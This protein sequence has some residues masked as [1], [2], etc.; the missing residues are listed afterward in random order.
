MYKIHFWSTSFQSA[1][2]FPN[3]LWI[4]LKAYL[5]RQWRRKPWAAP[6]WETWTVVEVLEVTL[7]WIIV[8]FSLIIFRFMSS[9]SP[10]KLVHKF[11]VLL[12]RV[13]LYLSSLFIKTYR[14]KEI[15]YTTFLLGLSPYSPAPKW[16]FL[17][18]NK[19]PNKTTQQLPCP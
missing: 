6:T 14:M 7:L 11:Q 8:F 1:F 18:Q 3:T 15:T 5:N 9:D 4:F 19:H 17:M 10:K 13:T 2:P 16:L 12:W